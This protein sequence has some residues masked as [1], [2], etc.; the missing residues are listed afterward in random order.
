MG[1]KRENHSREE[2][3]EADDN[4]FSAPRCVGHPTD[5]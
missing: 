3:R 2:V 4:W 1:V 5:G